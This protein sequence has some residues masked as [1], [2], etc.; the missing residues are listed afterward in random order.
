MKCNVQL[1][2]GH[3]G[4][5]FTGQLEFFFMTKTHCKGEHLVCGFEHFMFKILAIK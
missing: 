4:K 2:M 5:Q 1:A 3:F